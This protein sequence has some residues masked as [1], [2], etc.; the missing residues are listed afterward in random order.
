MLGDGEFHSGAAL[1]R[2]FNVSRGTIWQALRNLQDSG[3]EIFAV[4]GKGYR[5]SEPLSWLDPARVRT[6]LDSKANFIHIDFPE[7]TESTNTLL[8]Q[9]AALGAA[10]GS[11][12]VTECQMHGRGR[13]GRAWFSGLG[14][15]LTFS[16]LWR[17]ERGVGVLSGLSLAV[18]V[19]VARALRSLGARRIALKWPNDVI[20]DFHKLAGILV[21][22]QGDISGPCSAIIGIGIN[23]KIHTRIR[24]KIDQAVTDIDALAQPLPDKS[25]V[26]AQTLNSLVAVLSEF[27]KSGF[28][29]FREEWLR[30]HAY[31]NKWV[32]LSFA[33][34]TEHKGRV[35][36]VAEDGS[37]V[38]QTDAGLQRYNSGEI[39]LRALKE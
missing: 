38:L 13:R 17:F 24:E 39:S 15:G 30:Y 36:D 21:E 25:K 7:V 4:R 32:C 9:K 23:Y 35:T 37:L 3:L 26:L 5:L 22:I 14:G 34:N 20:S 29:G 18:S 11:C 16:L 2:H 1:A 12:V 10:H 31:Q 8:A 28:A 19:A 6:L 33:N 27:E